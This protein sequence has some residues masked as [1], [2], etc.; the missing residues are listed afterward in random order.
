MS[1][2]NP[3]FRAMSDHEF[4]PFGLST[5]TIHRLDSDLEWVALFQQGRE[6]EAYTQL[7]KDVAFPEMMSHIRADP[8]EQDTLPLRQLQYMIA[9]SARDRGQTG[10]RVPTKATGFQIAVAGGGPAGL[11]A[12][13]RLLEK[14]HDVHLFEREGRLGGAPALLYPE[15]RLPDPQDEIAARLQPAI[16]AGRLTV[17]LRHAVSRDTW[18]QGD[19]AV[20]LTTGCW[21]ETSLGTIKGVWSALR[22][23]R[24]ARDGHC[25]TVPEK[26]AVLCGGD[27]AMDVAVTARN[28]GAKQ[29]D[30]I[31]ETPR[32]SAYWHLPDSWFDKP[33][34]GARFGILP[35]GYRAEMDG[36]VSGVVLENDEVIDAEMVIEA[37]G[38]YADNVDTRS[39][40][41]FTAGALANG[42]ASVQQ[43]MREGFA[44][45]DDID[46]YL[47]SK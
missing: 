23:L 31:F 30:L 6:E 33:G 32:E 7:A 24:E 46:L 43:C 13:I 17:S 19:D 20:L 22:F 15:D 40:A 11:A 39:A 8:G 1:E 41:L 18:P 35:T 2:L 29:L 28:L 21:N 4:E 12:A 42:G 9:W 25:T 37:M 44:V 45:A 5:D 3:R 26:V 36:A 34:V 27:A 10:I 16:Q 47:Q 38:L 14:G